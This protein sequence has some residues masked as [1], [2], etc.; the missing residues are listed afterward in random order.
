VAGTGIT[1]NAVCPGYVDT[2]M[3]D[4]SVANIACTTGRSPE[5][6]RAALE[7]TS[8]LGRLVTPDEVAAAVAWLV[9]PEGVAVNGQA[10]V[11]DG[12]GLQK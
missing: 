3:T 2:P 4:T 8:A 5:E 10:I 11:I 6:A 12:G 9:S 1:S 7:R